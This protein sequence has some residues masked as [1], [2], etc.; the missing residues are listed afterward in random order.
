MAAKC[1]RYL[2]YPIQMIISDFKLVR[3][4][5]GRC[6]GSQ[7]DG[8]EEGGLSET[9]SARDEALDEYRKTLENTFGE[10][11]RISFVLLCV[12][13]WTEGG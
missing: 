11:G 3:K 12:R 2:I 5:D 13:G 4:P 9:K 10:E 6:A 7:Q 8:G 1:I